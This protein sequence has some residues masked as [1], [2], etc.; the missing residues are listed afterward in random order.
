MPRDIDTTGRVNEQEVVIK[1]IL[2]ERLIK[3]NKGIPETVLDDLLAEI[4]EL[5]SVMSDFM[6]N[7]EVYQL[8]KDG[9]EVNFNNAEGRNVTERVRLIDFD[10]ET[11]N[12]YLVVS[13]LWIRQKAIPRR[14]DLI[15]F[16]NGLPLVFIEL[17]NSNIKLR[18]AHSDNLTNYKRDIPLLFHYNIF[19]ILSNGIET[20]V[21]SFSA[22]WEHYF[23]W[24]RIDDEKKTPDKE[25]IKEFGVSLDYAVLG[26]CQKRRLLDYVENFILYY[27]DAVKICAKNHQFL[28]VNNAVESFRDRLEKDKLGDKKDKGK[29]GVFWHTQGS[30]KS[31]SM[32]FFS[33]KVFRKFT[34]NYTFVIVTDRDDLDD[35]IYRNFLGAGAVGKKE[36]CRPKNSDDLREMLQTNQ[37]FVFTLIQKFRYERGKQYPVLSTRNDIVVIVD[38]AHRTQYKELAENMRIGL[39]A[40]QYMAF[41]GTPLFGSRQLTNDWFGSTV[42]EYNFKQS[43]DDGATVPL[44]YQKRVPEVH[45]QNEQLDD[46]LAEIVA[47][48]NL[49]DAQ[50]EKLEKEHAQELSVLKADDRLETIATDIVLSF[51]KTRLSG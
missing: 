7:K 32:I 43:I 50:Q 5:R 12:N 28:G 39:P 49:T 41:T 2:K 13:Q 51:S 25:R 38:E 19:C 45:L 47:D 10:D 33:R 4:C 20:K 29:L 37:R 15:V 23:P 14:P 6:A 44:F 16:V 22:G 8:L 40:A 11:Q 9:K 36:K 35:Q 17:K 46:D 42:S 34:G 30:G 31:Y 21:G 1:P 24:L 26:L 48:E 3:L 18:N 27:K